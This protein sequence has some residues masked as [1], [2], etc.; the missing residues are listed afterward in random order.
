[1]AVLCGED[2]FQRFLKAMKVQKGDVKQLLKLHKE[3]TEAI[4]IGKK[5]IGKE[6]R[7][8]YSVKKGSSRVR[9]GTNSNSVSNVS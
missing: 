3:A 2:I 8:L 5:I 4:K 6:Q 9:V 1:M 7:R